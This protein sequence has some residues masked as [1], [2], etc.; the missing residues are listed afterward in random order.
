MIFQKRRG[1]G[2]SDTKQSPHP[3]RE[4]QNNIDGVFMLQL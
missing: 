4:K 2:N 3:G 1:N